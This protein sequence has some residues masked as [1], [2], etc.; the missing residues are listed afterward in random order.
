M[1]CWIQ[2]P[3]SNF[4]VFVRTIP[5]ALP[6]CRCILPRH[7]HHCHHVS[8]DTDRQTLDLGRRPSHRSRIGRIWRVS[9]RGKLGPI[10]PLLAAAVACLVSTDVL[11]NSAAI[12]MPMPPFCSLNIDRP[13]ADGKTGI[14]R[15]PADRNPS[16]WGFREMPKAVT[17]GGRRQA[18][19]ARVA[20]CRVRC[21]NGSITSTGLK[22][23]K[24]GKNG[25]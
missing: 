20:R 18:L 19:I 15:Q 13:Q 7:R 21:A 6:P 3:S 12:A 23:Q 25:R 22:L 8:A 14:L 16:R 17:S 2:V 4:A 5:E 10:G 9:L 24:V 11:C 1:V